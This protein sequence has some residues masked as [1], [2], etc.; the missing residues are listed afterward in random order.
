[1]YFKL[2]GEKE[3]CHKIYH[4]SEKL[5]N[6]QSALIRVLQDKFLHENKPEDKN[7]L[8]HLFSV[9]YPFSGMHYVDLPFHHATSVLSTPQNVAPF[10]TGSKKS[11][12]SIH[13]NTGL[14]RYLN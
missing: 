14:L 7:L 3:Q 2:K 10:K 6:H 4:N 11:E 1:M 12:K 8:K 13:Q 9:L 5:R